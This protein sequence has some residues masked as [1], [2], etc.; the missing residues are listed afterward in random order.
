MDD[1]VLRAALRL[2]RGLVGVDLENEAILV[3]YDLLANADSVYEQIG[4]G[5]WIQSLLVVGF[6]VWRNKQLIKVHTF[7]FSLSQLR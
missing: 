5:S 7:L 6:R 3:V 1:L 4:R 2:Q